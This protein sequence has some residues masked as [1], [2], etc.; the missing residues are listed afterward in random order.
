MASLFAALAEKWGCVA[1]VSG[2]PVSFLIEQLG[3]AGRTRFHG[4]Y[5][6]EEG[7]AAGG[8][9]RLHPEA[10]RWRGA[11]ADA[12][13]E[14]ERSAPPG[15][16]VERKAL[17]FTLHYRANPSAIDDVERLAARLSAGTGLVAHPGKKSLELRPPL[18]IDKGT[19][20]DALT[21]GL[22]ALIFAGD[23]LGDLPAFDVLKKR[24]SAG[25][26]TVSIASGGDETPAE[27]LDDADLVV[28]GPEGVRDVLRGLA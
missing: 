20:V 13:D 2:R 4:L 15:V 7:D 10:E 6:I 9:V 22:D 18:R 3:G 23:D 27:I 8:G 1:V 28:E 12:A 14:A 26:V 24:R 17:T 19:V 5:G 21:E 16:A 25:A 11:V